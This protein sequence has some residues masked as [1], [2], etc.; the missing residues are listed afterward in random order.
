MPSRC[1]D[2][3]IFRLSLGH[4]TNNIRLFLSENK[5]IFYPPQFARMA[6]ESDRP[7]SLI[8]PE[9]IAIKNVQ[10]TAACEVTVHFEHR[11]INS[12]CYHIRVVSC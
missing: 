2:A 11:V 9:A 5:G 12:S 1:V 7:A 10:W 6:T 3:V 8:F 4:S